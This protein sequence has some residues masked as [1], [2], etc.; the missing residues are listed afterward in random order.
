MYLNARL[1]CSIGAAGGCCGGADACSRRASAMRPVIETLELK[2]IS[3]SFEAYPSF[4]MRRWCLPYGRCENVA[5][6]V[7]VVEPSRI[8][9]A[10]AGSVLTQ[11]APS[12]PE[13]VGCGGVAFDLACSR[14]AR[15][16]FPCSLPWWPAFY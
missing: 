7:M 14:W 12:A 11:I 8:A 3:W 9:V 4:S 10:P 13:L 2:S 15:A 1:Y 6:V 5:G 16:C